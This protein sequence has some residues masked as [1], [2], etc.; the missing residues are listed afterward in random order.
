MIAAALLSTLI[1]G[2]LLALLGMRDPKRLRNAG[3]RSRELVLPAPMRTTF[4]W[5][6]LTPGIVLVA[7]AQWWALLIW[8]GAIGGLGWLT[9]TVLASNK[10]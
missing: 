7:M 3:H 6:V 4:G 9:A 10:H 8:L 1:S 2:A 5:L